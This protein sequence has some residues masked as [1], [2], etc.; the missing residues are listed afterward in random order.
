MVR[1]K[2]AGL[3]HDSGNALEAFGISK[4]RAKELGALTVD[5]IGKCKFNSEIVE[6]LWNN[7]KVSDKEFCYVLLALALERDRMA[8]SVFFD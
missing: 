2:L 8:L 4:A 5:V 1:S 6:S 3:K 7:K